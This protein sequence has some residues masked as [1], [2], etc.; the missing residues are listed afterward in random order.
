VHLEEFAEGSTL[1][2]RLDPRVKFLSTVPLVFVTAIMQGIKGP[3]AAL[4]VAVA[5]AAA[6][7]LDARKLLKRLVAVNAFLLLL[8]V[9]LPFSHPGAVVFSLGPLG[10][11]R[12]G[13]LYVLGITLK[14]NAIVL[15]TIAVF[16]T[17]EVFHLAHALV[18]L[19]APRK[20]V[21]L[22]FFFYRYLSVLH[23]EYT[24]LRQAMKIRCFRPGTN[25]HTY[26]TYA[27]LAGMLIVRSYERSERIYDAMLCRG[28]RGH[29]PLVRHFHMHGSDLAF[30][31]VMA[32][33]TGIMLMLLRT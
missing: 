13:L 14:G 29:F 17:S 33:V 22:F 20:L 6:A 19:K 15:M 10:A 24:R 31:A 1:L 27:C 8:W 25:L 9:F 16:G 2:H 11:T 4:S 18:H 21:Y 26:R 7:R 28:F 12:E 32:T 3:V 23:E 5:L 30:A